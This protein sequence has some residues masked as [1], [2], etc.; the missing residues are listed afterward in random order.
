MVVAISKM[1]CGCYA[2]LSK[3]NYYNEA[4]KAGFLTLIMNENTL[5]IQKPNARR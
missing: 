3:N 4:P 2:H 5:G 1:R